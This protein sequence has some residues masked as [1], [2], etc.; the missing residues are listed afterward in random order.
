M[1]KVIAPIYLIHDGASGRI[2]RHISSKLK[3]RGNVLTEAPLLGQAAFS[4]T[5]F[6]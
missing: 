2:R 6:L 5:K 3:M 1:F 4:F